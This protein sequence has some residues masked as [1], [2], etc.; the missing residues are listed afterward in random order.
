LTSRASVQVSGEK[1]AI[2]LDRQGTPGLKGGEWQLAAA[3]PEALV[4]LRGG[5]ARPFLAGSLEALSMPEVVGLILSGVRTGKLFLAHGGSRRT[6]SFKDGQVVFATSTE[7]QER[8]GGL[9]VRKGLLTEAQLSR[10]LE[11]V[12]PQVR[13]GQVLTR[14]QSLTAA[15]LYGA[16][17][18][19]V[20]DIVLA[21]FELGQGAFL[22]V[23]APV[24]HEDALKLPMR[25]RDLALEGMKRSEELLHLR[26]QLPLH[27]MVV[28]GPT[29][30]ADARETEAQAKVKDGANVH[31]L[32]ELVDGSEREF[33]QWATGL[34]GRKVLGVQE[35]ARE[36]APAGK[37][38]LELY[39]ELVRTICQALRNAGKDLSELRGFF[40]HPAP[41]L[42]EAFAGVSLSEEG[43]L[44]VARVM[45]NVSGGDQALSRALAYEALDAFANY[46]LFSAKNALPP[47]LAELLAEEFRRVSEGR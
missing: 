17:A 28:P 38:A 27:L 6:I 5:Q 29:P 1:L 10:A 13:L 23:E 21:S 36:A 24:G 35:P 32:R 33:L 30:P 11:K 9:L 3:F 45:A 44:D 8:L 25:T 43:T 47:E 18:E 22:F 19:L 26:A 4:L 20:Q 40:D 2:E 41:G 16:M 46:A 34:L 14:D 42:E 37:S 39:V 31:A 15:A 7:P 12:G